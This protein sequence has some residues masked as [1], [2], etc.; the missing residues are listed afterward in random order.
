ADIEIP[1]RR[2]VLNWSFY[3]NPDPALP[4]SHLVELRFTLASSASSAVATVPGLLMKSAEQT[5]GVPLAS[6]SVRV[7]D[8]VFL[9][10]LSSFAPD[11]ERNIA[12]LKT[13]SWFDIPIIY[14]DKRRAIIA[15]EKGIAGTRAFA[16]GFA[17]WGQ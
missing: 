8:N 16:E 3:V 11:M 1:D 9:I 2:L 7:T 6:R 10:G 13:G 4:A 14:D 5:R 15:L 12:N 17:T